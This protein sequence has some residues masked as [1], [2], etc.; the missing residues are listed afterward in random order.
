L[1][2]VFD[3]EDKLTGAILENLRKRLGADFEPS[4]LRGHTSNFDAH[5]LYLR[6]RHSFNQQTAAG[7]ADALRYF[8]QALNLAPNY[9]LAHVGLADCYA[10]QGWYGLELPK[11]VMPMAKA[12]LETALRI[13]PALPQ[14]W[15]LRAAIA[16]GFD[17]N[18]E[19]AR[20]DFQQAFALGS[21]TSDLHFHHA[22][23][24]LTPLQKLDEAL[25]EIKLAVELDPLAPLVSTAVGGCLYR[26]RRYAAALQQLQSTLELD[27]NFYHAHWT[28]ARVYESKRQFPQ[29]LECFERAYAASGK[30]PAVLADWCHCHGAMGEQTAAR[31][32]L[33][34]LCAVAAEGYLSPLTLATAYLGLGESQAAL[35][36]LAKAVEER[37]RGLIWLN[38]D[39]RFDSLKREAAYR[40]IMAPIGLAV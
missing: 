40:D 9:A 17:W 27:P 1:K 21:P 36:H 28:M 19:Q 30:T 31:N 7:V 6:A 11:H 15:C 8:S 4:P 23:D 13:E 24:F 26:S 5:E 10:L 20:H 37:T 14:A 3:V 29:A 18:W 34:R 25:E 35:D 2:D 38:V 22:L 32:I 33:A 12:A 16:T 39:P